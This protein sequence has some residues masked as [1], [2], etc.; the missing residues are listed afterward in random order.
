M[1]IV[2]QV[3]L[4]SAFI[5]VFSGFVPPLIGKYRYIDGG[6]TDNLPIVDKN[7]ITISPFS[8]LTD[9]CPR[10][11]PIKKYLV[12]NFIF[13]LI[14]IDISSLVK[15]LYAKNNWLILQHIVL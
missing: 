3:L 10:G 14:I 4:A 8:G 13:Y 5:P 12:S 11:N 7:T 2:F 9:I 6:F 1:H 15:S